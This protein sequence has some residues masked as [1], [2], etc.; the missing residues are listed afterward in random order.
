VVRALA[1]RLLS[2]A[3]L[4]DPARILP[5]LRRRA[6]AWQALLAE[7]AT[8]PA[9]ADLASAAHTAW[10][11]L[12]AENVRWIEPASQQR[13]AV[14]GAARRAMDYTTVR[15]SSHH[16][17]LRA[18]LRATFDI[19][20]GKVRLAAVE[21]LAWLGPEPADLDLLTARLGDGDSDVRAAVV[22]RLVAPG[23][24]AWTL[25]KAFAQF[26]VREAARM[27]LERAG[28]W[29]YAE[30][31]LSSFLAPSVAERG[32][33]E[34]VRPDA[35]DDKGVAFALALRASGIAPDA[36]LPLLELAHHPDAGELARFTLR[37]LAGDQQRALLD[38][39][40]AP[41]RLRWDLAGRVTDMAAPLFEVFRDADAQGFPRLR[42]ESALRLAEAA[43]QGEHWSASDLARLRG[44]RDGLPASYR[45]ALDA[46]IADLER[47]SLIR[48]AF[49][50]VSLSVL[51]HIALWL[52]LV[53]AYPY[54][55]VVQAVF[56]WNP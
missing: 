9:A 21:T 42:Q 51:A 34:G 19:P 25:G 2:L 37:L 18:F 54:S 55:R 35:D 16:Q 23:T 44:W 41:Q 39:V 20:D 43:Q 33:P 32:A 38:L 12:E 36:W 53:T 40:G 10:F 5:E 17:P 1:A 7:S 28:A 49:G 56:F 31:T 27:T 26:A 8:D 52:A 46:R 30:G 11:M 47:E 4:H 22:G 29:A 15:V 50:W 48:R 14:L 13:K 3:A 24:P 6:E 45:P